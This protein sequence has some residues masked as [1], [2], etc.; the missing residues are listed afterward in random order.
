MDATQWWSAVERR[1]PAWDGRFV[2]AVR[3]TGVYCRP[4]CPARR[5]RRGQVSF[6]PAPDEAERAGFRSCRRCHPRQASAAEVQAVWVRAACAWLDRHPEGGSLAELS[7][8]IG[9]SP[10]HLHRTFRRVMGVTPRQYRD[11]RRL[12]RLREE[13]KAGA[14]VTGAVI[15]AGYGS[16]S[17]VYDGNGP[18]LGMTPASYRRGG[19]GLRVTYATVK[20][21]LGRLLVAATERGVCAVKLGTSARQLERELEA[22][23]PA[24]AIRRDPA[25][26][27]NRVRGVLAHLEDPHHAAP[28]PLDL[29]ASAFQLRVWSAL[30]TIPPGR[31][32][33]YG[34]IARKLGRPG[35]ARAVASACAG[36]P[37][38]LLVPCHR[39]VRGSGATGGYR[40]G[41]RRKAWL[42]TRERGTS[43]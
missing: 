8:H 17:R 36:N 33:S 26:L 28:L 19:A 35:A 39:V 11:A 22:E 12:G 34:A 7:R 2:Y 15:E 20:C 31:T 9:Y 21:A 32:A 37:V 42:L 10:H 29:K 6:F 25:A 1:D 16:T 38:A 5:P 23:L 18:K 4:S 41:A 3:S 30:R 40:W 13:L 14:P 27:A 43:K 24:A